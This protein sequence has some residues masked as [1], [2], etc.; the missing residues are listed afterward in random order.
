MSDSMKSFLSTLSGRQRNLSISNLVWTDKKLPKYGY[1]N[2]EY[3]QISYGAGRYAF[4]FQPHPIFLSEL[5][6]GLRK[7]YY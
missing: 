1:E 2:S 4:T 5:R 3:Q 6:V 7:S